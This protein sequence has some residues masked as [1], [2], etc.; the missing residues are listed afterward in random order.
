MFSP[1]RNFRRLL[2]RLLKDV[3]GGEAIEM[4]V[5][6]APFIA[7]VFAL[8]ELGLVFMVSTSLENATDEAARKIRTGELQISGG[9]ATTM[10]AAIC[11]EMAWLA[12]TCTGKLNLDVRT[13]TSF[14]SQSAPPDPVPGGTVTPANFCWDPGGAGSIVLVRAYYR[15]TLILPVLN[16]GLKTVG[17]GNDRLITSATS[18]RNEPYTPA[19]P[20]PVTC[21]VPVP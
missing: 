13:F 14:A 7:L 9:N 5:V 16:A 2:R 20:T 15:W 18:F 17:A 1:L 11:A 4:A 8:L 10:K 12:G 21:P 19:T 3:R 6:G